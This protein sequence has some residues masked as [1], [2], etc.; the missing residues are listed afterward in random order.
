[1]KKTSERSIRFRTPYNYDHEMERKESNMVLDP[2]TGELKPMPSC[3]VPDQTI[4]IREILDRT[5]RKQIVTGALKGAFNPLDTSPDPRSMDFVERKAAIERADQE[6]AEIKKRQDERNAAKAAK[7]RKMEEDWKSFQAM[8]EK[9]AAE[10]A[11]PNTN[12]P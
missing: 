6:L 9:L 11:A 8:R 4:P 3:T 10:K 2:E 7:K 1:M 12:T 5:K